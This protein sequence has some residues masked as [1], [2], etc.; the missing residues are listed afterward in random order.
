M[1]A[2]FNNFKLSLGIQGQDRDTE[3][4]NI[5]RGIIKE[6]YNTYGIAL[7]KDTLSHTETVN[8]TYNTTITLAYKNIVS[9]SIAG[10]NE[11][12]DYTLDY[13]SGEL[14]IL[15]SG[16]MLENT[17]YTVSYDYY[18]FINESNEILYYIYPETNEQ[19][20]HVDVKPNT[21]KKVEYNGNVLTEDVDYYYFNNTFEVA[22]TIASERIPYILYLEVG[23]ETIPT[24]LK[25][26]FYE[27]VG[28]RF[29]MRDKKTYLINKVTDNAQ[30]IS[31][32][33]NM[34]SLPKHIE[35]I[36]IS[37]TGRRFLI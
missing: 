24:D 20:Y 34:N 8:S 23:Y 25:H 31:T 35:N 14:T 16:S 21:L 11:D 22:A 29:D 3:Y 26:A 15:D 12:V 27:L 30:G 7:T 17:D 18:L 5:M 4:A 10:M 19:T 1:E 28:I 6:L 37:Y 36:L 32:T 13:Y 33:Y 9:L 2:S